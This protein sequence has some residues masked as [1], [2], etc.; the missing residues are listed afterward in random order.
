VS[1][2]A[3]PA[4]AVASGK[5][6]VGKTT[7][8]VNTALAL[9]GLGLRVGLVDADLYGPDAAHLLGLRRGPDA[10]SVTLFGRGRP[11][12]AWRRSPGTACRS[13]RPRS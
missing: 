4:V 8:A 1:T 9:T 13:P 7:V 5:G 12:R 11:R 3:V 2:E 6:G 10:T